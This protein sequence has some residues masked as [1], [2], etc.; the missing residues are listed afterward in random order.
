MQ[1]S[2]S[3]TTVQHDSVDIY[4]GTTSEQ[5]FPVEIDGARILLGGQTKRGAFVA[6]LP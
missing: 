1:I 3:G 4:P 6:R 2:A 5:V